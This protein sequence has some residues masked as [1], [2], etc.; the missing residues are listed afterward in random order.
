MLDCYPTKIWKSYNRISQYILGARIKNE[1]NT[2]KNK[3]LSL[4]LK[5]GESDLI[6]KD[7]QNKIVISYSD[8]RA[9]KDD[10]N[11]QRGILKLEKLIRTKRLTK[12]QINNKGY[13]KFLKM[14]GEVE[15]ILDQTKIDHDKKWDG[16]KGYL[17][18]TALRKDEIINNYSHL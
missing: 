12:T 5:N 15:V 3:I 2:V 10:Y 7:E 6:Q 11:R 17:T 4:K 8:S 9:K 14:T 18:N 16:L 1:S 13:N